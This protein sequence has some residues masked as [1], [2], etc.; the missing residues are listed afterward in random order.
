MDDAYAL[1]E[2][3]SNAQESPV[4]PPA[5]SRKAEQARLL[6]LE[7]QYCSHGDTVHYT[8][9]SEDLFG[10]RRLVHVR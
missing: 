1:L 5:I 4:S 10:L 2:P 9:V 6:A 3:G 8:A 7:A